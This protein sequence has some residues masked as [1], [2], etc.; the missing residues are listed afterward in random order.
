[1]EE[2][3]PWS[4]RLELGNE[5][6]NREH[7]LQIAL[8]SALADA[9]E[10]G[11]PWVA[12]RVLDQLAGYTAAHFQGEELLMETAAYEQL[13]EHREEHRTL[14]AH[15]D[16]IRYLVNGGEHELA[17][18]MALDLRSGLGSHIAASDRLFADRG[19]VLS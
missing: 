2:T 17:L 15:I 18:P 19:A 10:Q 12:R 16:E 11:R 7:H 5:T 6:L 13:A 14:C 4:P 1:M 3:H 9:L 8:V